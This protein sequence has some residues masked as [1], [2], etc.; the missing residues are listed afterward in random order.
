VSQVQL[1]PS[2]VAGPPEPTGPSGLRTDI[3]ALR[4]LAVA[5]VVAFHV[6]PGGLPGGYV[7]VDVF[8]VISGFLIGSHLLGELQGTGR[9]RL[10]R[11]WARRAKRLLPA[12][13]TVLLATAVTVL[14]VSPEALQRDFLGKVVAATLYVENW[15]LLRDAV[16]Y[17]ASGAASSPTQHFWSLSAEEQFY[18]AL[19]LL[20]LLAGVL[21]TLA[22]KLSGRGLTRARTAAVGAVL[23]A[24]LLASFGY[25]LWA[26][27]DSPQQAYFSTA[28][29]AWEFLAGAVLALLPVARRTAAEALAW[30]GVGAVAL[31]CV[32][33]SDTTRFPGWPALLP[34]L[35]AAVAI[36]ANART[37]CAVGRVAPVAWLGEV[38]YA[39]Y[40]WHWPLVVLLPQILGHRLGTADRLLLLVLT[41]ALAHLSTRFLEEPI[42]FSPRLLGGRRS[43]A[44]VLVVCAAA[45]AVVAGTALTATGRLEARQHHQA[46][47]TAHVLQDANRCLGAQ[48]LDPDLA[49]C[50]NPQL[51]GVLVP[52][53]ATA[54]DDD[55]NRPECWGLDEDGRARVCT[56]VDPPGAT[57]HLLALGDSHNNSLVEAYAM[58][59][60]EHGWR[61]DVAGQRGCYL[62]TAEQPA[63]TKHL[64]RLCRDW[65][66]SALALARSDDVDGVVVTHLARSP[67]TRRKGLTTEQT[68][69]D[70]LV[71]AWQ[72]LPDVPILAIRDNPSLGSQ[73]VPCVEQHADDPNAACARSRDTALLDDGQAAAA[74]QVPRA[75]VVDMSDFYCTDVCP[76]V[77]G[78]VLV[79][80]DGTHI[81]RT[82]ARTLAPYLGRRMADAL[83]G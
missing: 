6:W 74:A 56:A 27:Q 32:V 69:V 39:V 63:P 49:P 64:T 77:I 29:R 16:D 30:A 40:L 33:F 65:V 60:A 23:T 7:G 68:V 50:D 47:L 22:A 19:P 81:T 79:F 70:G 15:A 31:A 9:I 57:R 13:L 2:S 43:S 1:A 48:A 26:V 53:P 62:S 8:F 45:M 59:G 21:A 83:G 3:Q 51:H 10:G 61:I 72:Q 36:R 17:Q 35:G 24:L 55:S 38:S 44:T 41:G 12:S 71:G 67:V 52:A 66:S 42:R 58:I 18:V 37:L 80:R 34:V 73:V 20:L 14:V 46:E 54:V 76:P 82:W 11:F 75:R 78:H 25:A 28:T 5:V 4:A